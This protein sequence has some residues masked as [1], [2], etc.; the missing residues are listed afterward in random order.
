MYLK[1]VNQKAL[2]VLSAVLHSR[3]AGARV[4]QD[5]RAAS[6]ELLDRC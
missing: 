4:L 1:C 2:W 6:V 3:E 5:R